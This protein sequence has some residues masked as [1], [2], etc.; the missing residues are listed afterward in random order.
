MKRIGLMCWSAFLVV[1]SVFCTTTVLSQEKGEG[2]AAKPDPMEQGLAMYRRIIEKGGEK[3][4]QHEWLSN[5]AGSFAGKGTYITMMGPVKTASK[6]KHELVMGGRFLRGSVEGDLFGIEFKGESWLGYDKNRAK[7]IEVQ[8]NNVGTG[9]QILEG[10]MDEAGK[11]LTLVGRETTLKTEMGEM[12]YTPKT[13]L[14]LDDEGGGF[15]LERYAL[16]NGAWNKE[17]VQRYKKA[18]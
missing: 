1:S 16:M 3:V 17:M 5:Q 9:V 10:D 12:K 2:E 14:T 4:K 6:V 18:E 13:V 7:W 8:I 11:I 15:K